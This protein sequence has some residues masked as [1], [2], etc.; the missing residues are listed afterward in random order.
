MRVVSKVPN[1]SEHVP[2][3]HSDNDYKPKETF[4]WDTAA[5]HA[6]FEREYLHARTAVQVQYEAHD[7]KD[8]IP[9]SGRE[10]V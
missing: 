6:N 5:N 8:K 10:G 2:H 4:W 3:R 1:Y 7:Q 9:A